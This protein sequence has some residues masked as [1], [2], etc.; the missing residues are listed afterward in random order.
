MCVYSEV[1]DNMIRAIASLLWAAPRCT[2]KE[3]D[4]I[5]EALIFWYRVPTDEL[6]ASHTYVDPEL[7]KSLDMN[8]P[9]DESVAAVVTRVRGAEETGDMVEVDD[10][11]LW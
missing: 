1:P 5:R 3:L 8:L 11:L 9:S 6:A 7:V 4:W 10:P 2:I